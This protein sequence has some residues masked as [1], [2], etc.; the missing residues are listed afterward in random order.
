MKKSICFY[1]EAAVPGRFKVI[2]NKFSQRI[3]DRKSVL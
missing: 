3:H 2:F 1:D